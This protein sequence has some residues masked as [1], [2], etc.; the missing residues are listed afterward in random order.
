MSGHAG[1]CAEA[2]GWA[3][4]GWWC[5]I[6]DDMADHLTSEHP[7]PPA[8]ITPVPNKPKTPIRSFR[9]PQ[10]EYDAAKV[11]ADE[12]GETLTDVVR[13]SLRR[14]AKRT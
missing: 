3:D 8:V 4:N 10:D 9:I 14:Y 11:K 7:S 5:N 12:R 6:C 2:S 1:T 13:R